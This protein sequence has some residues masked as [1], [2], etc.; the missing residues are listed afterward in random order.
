VLRVRVHYPLG[1]NALVLRTSQDWDHDLVPVET[2]TDGAIFEI[3]MTTPFVAVK[4]CL[5]RDGALHWS[6][7]DN[8]VLSARDPDPLIWPAF[9]ASRQGAVSPLLQFEA[10]GGRAYSVRV[11]TPPGYSENTL[12]RFAVLYMQDGRNLFFPEEAFGGKEWRVDETMDRLDQMNSVRKVIVVGIAPHDRMDDYTAPGYDA[13]GAFLTS[14][15]KPAID[16]RWRTRTDPGSA[17]VSGSSLGG[18]VS[19]HL[20][21]RY[22]DVFGGAMCLSS[23]FGFKDDLFERV[24]TEAKPPIRIY[25]DSGWP[26]DNYDATNAMRDLLVTRGFELGDDLLSFSFPDGAHNEGS[27]AD[28]LH[29]PFQY[30]FGRAWSAARA[31]RR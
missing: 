18:V 16:A 19:L 8:Y 11:Y 17:V 29:V 26:R 4:P 9:F 10:P 12:R 15:L 30:F 21:W 25:L 23:T 2:W 27:W 7:G 1:G 13:Y 28:R 20:A 24:A 3:E 5:H 6:V 31:R 14:T 22:P